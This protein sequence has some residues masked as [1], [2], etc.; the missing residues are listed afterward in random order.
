MRG[1]FTLRP[2]I[3]HGRFVLLPEWGRRALLIASPSPSPNEGG[4]A[5]KA[6][7]A[8]WRLVVGARSSTAHAPAAGTSAV[9]ACRWLGPILLPGSRPWA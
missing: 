7:A 4:T 1:I 6:A 8:A 2:H 3:L 5:A 9:A